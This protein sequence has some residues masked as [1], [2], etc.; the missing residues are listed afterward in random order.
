MAKIVWVAAAAAQ[1]AVQPAKDVLLCEGEQK[2][3]ENFWL[4]ISE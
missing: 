2:R 3:L 1:L 4:D